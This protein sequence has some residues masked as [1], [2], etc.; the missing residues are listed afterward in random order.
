MKNQQGLK[1]LERLNNCLKTIDKI[2][3]QLN[4]PEEVIEKDI[5]PF[6]NASHMIL[7]KQYQNKKATILIRK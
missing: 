1:K 3:K 7:P 5:K 6:G 4:V 2:M